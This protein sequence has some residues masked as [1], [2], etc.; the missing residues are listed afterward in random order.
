[1][2]K[3]LEL[4]CKGVFKINENPEVVNVSHYSKVTF[5]NRKFYAGF[6]SYFN[7]T[8]TGPGLE[9]ATKSFEQ[10]PMYH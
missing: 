2:W 6:P 10:S 4:V 7:Y 9:L 5:Q 8:V 1:M 3:N